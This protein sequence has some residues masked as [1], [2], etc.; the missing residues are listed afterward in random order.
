MSVV[1]LWPQGGADDFLTIHTGGAQHRDLVAQILG[2]LQFFAP[3]RIPIG[4]RRLAEQVFA[5]IAGRTR[6]AIGRKFLRH[7]KKP[8]NAGGAGPQSE[9]ALE[10]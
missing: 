5:G 2:E 1:R 3:T 8:L 6:A 7:E 4:A 10:I 9:R